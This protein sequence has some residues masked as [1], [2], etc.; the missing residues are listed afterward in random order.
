LNNEGDSSLVA[1]T[2]LLPVLKGLKN[3]FDFVTNRV[4]GPGETLR[5]PSPRGWQNRGWLRYIFAQVDNPYTIIEH[6]VYMKKAVSFSFW[7]T[8]AIGMWQATA[9]G[10]FTLKVYD[11]LR[12]IY[13]AESARVPP[14][15]FGPGT[16]ISIIA[17]D[18]NPITGEPITTNTTVNLAIWHAT[19][20]VDEEAFKRSL[21]DVVGKGVEIEGLRGRL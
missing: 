18:K 9:S 3:D 2:N 1:L 13:V 7:Q 15:E 12:N 21:R 14:D 16:I 5:I 6:N 20:I 8:W 19:L 11:T 4:L 17:P 10:F